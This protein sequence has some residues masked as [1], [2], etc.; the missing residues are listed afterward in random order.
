MSAE[1]AQQV[2]GVPFKEGVFVQAAE[3]VDGPRLVGSRCGRCGAHAFPKR[4]VCARCRAM[5]DQDDVLLGPS[6]S[7][8][9]FATVQHAPER[10]PT[11]YVIGYVDLDEGVRVFTQV[12]TDDPAVL[13]LGQRM[14]LT[15]GELSGGDR[16]EVQLA[17]RFRPDPGESESPR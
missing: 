4:I 16:G 12:E 9:T 14:T 13:Q 15:I 1:T 5:D 10:F 11:P 6:G 2:S 8:Y 7:L 3:G 17:Y